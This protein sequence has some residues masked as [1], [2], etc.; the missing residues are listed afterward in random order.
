MKSQTLIEQPQIAAIEEN[1]IR[2]FTHWHDE[3][4]NQLFFG[5]LAIIPTLKRF[6]QNIERNLAM[7]YVVGQIR[8]LDVIC[9]FKVA[10]EP[11][12]VLGCSFPPAEAHHVVPFRQQGV[13]NF[14]KLFVKQ[15][16]KVLI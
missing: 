12:L 6:R 9:L 13:F 10:D 14:G 16:I 8:L 5:V 4:V 1:V 11:F 15:K 2:C 7:E 3:L